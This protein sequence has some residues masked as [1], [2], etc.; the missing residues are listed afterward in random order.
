MV[1]DQDVFEDMYKI[2]FRRV[3]NYLA[4]SIADRNEISDLVADVFEKAWRNWSFYDSRKASVST[5]ILCIARNH[6]RDGWRKRKH[7]PPK[8]EVAET[9]IVSSMPSPEVTALNNVLIETIH[10]AVKLLS[11][12]E[13]DLIGLRYGGFLSLAEISK[14]VGK[15]TEAVAVALHR[16]IRKLRKQ[17]VTE[18]S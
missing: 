12:K 15:S 8:V 5:W 11:R 16:A 10:Q 13:Q 17:L 7:T 3:Y 2:H 1:V 14:I 4:Y 9:D 18:R 6:V